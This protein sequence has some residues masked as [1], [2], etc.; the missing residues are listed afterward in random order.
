M[1]SANSCGHT[2]AKQTHLFQ[3][4]IRVDF[5]DG[6]LRKNGV[7]GKCRRPHV[8]VEASVP[9][10]GSNESPGKGLSYPRDKN[11]SARIRVCTEGS[12]GRLPQLRSRPRQPP[13]Q[14]LHLHAPTQGIGM[15]D[16][17]RHVTKEHFSRT[18]WSDI[19]LSDIQKLTWSPSNRSSGANYEYEKVESIC[20]IALRISTTTVACNSKQ[21]SESEDQSPLLT[22]SAEAG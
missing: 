1:D 22:H 7:F 10:L 20:I 15:T 13:P 3:R 21:I 6:N 14:P 11:G 12:H 16:P 9:C 18:R 2:T 5:G 8:V 19:Y 4:S 17:C